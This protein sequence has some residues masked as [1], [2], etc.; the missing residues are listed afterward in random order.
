MNCTSIT[1]QGTAKKAVAFGQ[2]WAENL[3]DAE[4][5]TA[6]KYGVLGLEGTLTDD[7]VYREN[8][9]AYV[10]FTPSS[11]QY[12]E[13]NILGAI[14]VVLGALYTWAK[15]HPGS[16]VALA[17]LTT[18][19]YIAIEII[20][21]QTKVQEAGMSEDATV[22]NILGNKLLTGDQKLKLLMEYL[23]IKG[24]Q[25]TNWGDIIIPAVALLGLAYV[26]GN[27]LGGK[28]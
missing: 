4:L 20:D 28:R 19:A 7:P 11:E 26:A 12:I 16:L 25:G 24:D 8:N 17:G 18:L 22:N 23:G 14:R 15:A 9:K 5:K 3:N 2:F 27:M 13:A 1:I 6:A 21:W 10:V